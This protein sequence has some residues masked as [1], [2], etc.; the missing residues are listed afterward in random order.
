MSKEL[1]YL[2][3][4]CLFVVDHEDWESS[5]TAISK[6]LNTCAAEGRLCMLKGLST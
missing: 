3:K 4:L 5:R 1:Y 2:D 6:Q